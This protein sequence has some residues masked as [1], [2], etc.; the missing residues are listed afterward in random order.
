MPLEMK[1]FVL[2]PRAKSKDDAFASASQAALYSFG[3]NIQ[4]ADKDLAK[5][6]KAWAD[7]EAC[8]QKLLS[9]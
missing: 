3:Q 2:K 4:F 9:R 1:Y 5:E 8:V 7:R 6:L